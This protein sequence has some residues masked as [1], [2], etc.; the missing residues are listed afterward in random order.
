MIGLS[1]RVLV[2]RQGR[3]ATELTREQADQETILQHATGTQEAA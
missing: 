3:V 2:L 1:D